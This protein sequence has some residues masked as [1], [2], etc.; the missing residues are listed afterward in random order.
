MK[1]FEEKMFNFGNNNNKTGVEMSGWSK[2][3]K[4]GT[5]N[6]RHDYIKSHSLGPQI[7]TTTLDSSGSESDSSEELLYGPGF[8]SRLKSRYM[9][10]AL[11]GSTG[12][13]GKSSSNRKRPSLR[14]TASFEEFLEKEKIKNEIPTPSTTSNVICSGNNK[15]ESKP[16]KTSVSSSNK[17]ETQNRD[18]KKKREISKEES[19]KR[20]QSVEVLSI[21]TSESVV[22]RSKSKERHLD[23]ILDSLANDNILLNDEVNPKNVAKQRR[24]VPLLFGVQVRELPAPDT[25]RETRRLFEKVQRTMT[26]SGGQNAETYSNSKSQ[27]FHQTENRINR[28]ELETKNFGFDEK[29]KKA[30]L[31]S[32][33]I[34]KPSVPYKPANLH[35]KSESDHFVPLKTAN[36]TTKSH[37]DQVVPFKP[38]NLTTKSE[39]DHVIPFKPGNLKSKSHLEPIKTANLYSDNEKDQFKPSNLK[40]KTESDQVVPFKPAHLKIKSE[41]DLAPISSTNV[42]VGKNTGKQTKWVK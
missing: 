4:T 23:S 37:L 8:V 38:A 31:P 21:T 28:E 41:S 12:I 22:R 13:Y 39:S 10:V 16:S 2:S 24:S 14:R 20:C 27:C 36:L 40:F 35:S 11:R 34:G 9:S 26:S 25:V 17:C 19:F 29:S 30:S 32:K 15:Y 6:Y 7:T 18:S 1:K 42:T 3:S 33:P 5:G